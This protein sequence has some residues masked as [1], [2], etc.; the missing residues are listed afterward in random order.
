MPLRAV[1]IA[2]G[3]MASATLAAADPPAAIPKRGDVYEL[4]LAYATAEKSENDQGSSS[5]NGTTVLIE[6]VIAISPDGAE[7]EYDLPPDAK[8]EDRLRQWQFPARIF[9]PNSGSARLINQAALEARLGAW[10]ATSKISRTACGRWVFTWNAFKIEC[11]PISVLK[12]IA[13]VDMGW[14][15]RVEGAL[16]S[17]HAAAGPAKLARTSGVAG[18]SLTADLALNVDHVRKERA[19]ADV[20]VGEIMREPVK[21]EQAMQARAKEKISGSVSVVMSLDTADREIKRVTTTTMRRQEAEGQVFNATST[22][23]LQKRLLTS[24]SGS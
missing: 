12:T 4:R 5:S 20:V 7:L 24:V 16:S 23:T 18:S 11:D 1:S 6:R 15:K 2:C 10:L 13:S 21:L 17:T 19:E 9:R 22:E 3:L 8:P 14:D